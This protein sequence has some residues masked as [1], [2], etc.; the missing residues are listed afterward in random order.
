MHKLPLIR[1]CCSSTNET[2]LRVIVAIVAPSRD[3]SH[4]FGPRPLL[5]FRNTGKTQ[6]NQT[7]RWTTSSGF[8]QIFSL[9]LLCGT[10]GRSVTAMVIGLVSAVALS[11]PWSCHRYSRESLA[12]TCEGEH[13]SHLQVDVGNSPWR[14]MQ[15]LIKISVYKTALLAFLCSSRKRFA[16]FLWVGGTL[17]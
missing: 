15:V 7:K 8:R 4:G 6:P 14:A 12:E 16:Y 10:Q 17:V 13:W 9:A 5:H 2:S 11:L 1:I 3:H